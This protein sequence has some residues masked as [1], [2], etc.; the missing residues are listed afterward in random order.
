MLKLY[1]LK[2]FVKNYLLVVGSLVLIYLVVDFFER[3][4]EFISH[5]APMIELFLYYVY[6]VPFIFF[7]MAPQSVLLATV[8]TLA[9]LARNNEIVAMKACGIS[10]LGITWP[11]VGMSVLISFIVLLC[12]EYIA[13]ITNKKMNHIFYVKV[14]GKKL[15]GQVQQDKIWMKSANGSIWNIEHYDP[16]QAMM[17]NVSLLM[18]DDFHFVQQRI[19]AEQ[20]IWVKDRWE[21]MD[22]YVR[23]F[24]KEGLET[25]EF[26]D[27]STFP[28]T[29][30][31]KDF[32]KVQKR[33][34]EVSLREMIVSMKKHSQEGKDIDKEMMDFHHKVSYPFISIVLALLAIPLSLR[35]SRH[36][37]VM[38]CIAVSM[39]IGFLFSFLYA[40]GISL[41]HGGTFDP[42][43]AGWGAI[44]LFT[45]IGFYLI[46]TL[47]SE[48]ILPF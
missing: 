13:P 47:D 36:G 42:V 19:D 48:R 44:T 15:Y 11:I 27:Q 3:V 28:V 24:S 10:I 8:I 12:N 43:L 23:K 20:V 4:D 29:A 32:E 21:F 7:F 25:T 45:A 17:S 9:S 41:G 5:G 39:A 31:P 14:R 22:V 2:S 33:P 26:F 6:K 30:V 46:L 38:F 34:E 40:V 16:T 18:M 1:V 35:S 37:G